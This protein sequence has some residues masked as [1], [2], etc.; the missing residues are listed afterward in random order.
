[1]KYHLLTGATGLL[2]RYLLRDLTLADVPLAV[3]ARRSRV[4][5]AVQRIETSMAY[6]ESQLGRALVRP[7]VLEGDITEPGLG[8]SPHDSAWVAANVDTVIHSAASLTFYADDA[9]G[10]PWR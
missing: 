4:E 1:M 8:L 9:E 2:G 5:S 10:E 3:V 7:V 6:W